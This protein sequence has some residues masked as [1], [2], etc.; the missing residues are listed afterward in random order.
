AGAGTGGAGTGG[1]GT[2]GAG[3]G[4]GAGMGGAAASALLSSSDFN[5]TSYVTGVTS[6]TDIAFT[7]DGRAVVTLKGG[8]VV[9]RT[10]AGTLV[11]INGVFTA[12][13]GSPFPVDIESEKG[14][15]G[16]VADPDFA[17]NQRLYF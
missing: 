8:G 13:I 17:T 2:G 11:R 3:T 14:L 4:G 1:A 5:I 15:L 9:V 6:P 12:E 16:V 10:A 7:P